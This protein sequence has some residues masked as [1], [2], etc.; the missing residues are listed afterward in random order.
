MEACPRCAIGDWGTAPRPDGVR[1]CQTRRV[2]SP[3]TFMWWGAEGKMQATDG[4]VV[5][6]EGCCEHG[7]LSWEH[8]MTSTGRRRLR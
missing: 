6:R 3:E 4:C 7:H 5:G 1:H 8:W 2:P